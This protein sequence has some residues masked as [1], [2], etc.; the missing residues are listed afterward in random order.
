V[1]CSS[2]KDYAS[3]RHDVTAGIIAL[4]VGRRGRRPVPVHAKRVFCMYMR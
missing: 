3:L 1:I 2:D 4:S